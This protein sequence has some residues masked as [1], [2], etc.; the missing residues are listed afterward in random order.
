[1]AT[2]NNQ[3]PANEVGVIGQMYENRKTKKAG[4]LESR[5]EKF[6]TLMMRDNDGKAFNI[7]FSTFRSD[8]RKYQ[9]EE[10]IQTSTQIEEQKA[11]EKKEVTEAKKEVKK[12]KP[13]TMSTEEKV[14]AVKAVRKLLDE[15]I[16]ASSVELETKTLSNGGTVI[17]AK[18]KKRTLVE[19]WLPNKFP[20][21]YSFRMRE[22]LDKF[23]ETSEKREFLE[24][25]VNCVRYRPKKDDFESFIKVIITAIEKFV[26]ETDFLNKEKNE[27]NEEKE[28]N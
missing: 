9:G 10:V 17:K 20:D 14:K 7:N 22:D 5:D 12:E 25:D 11:E 28:K 4:V 13:A 3:K 23:V 27:K 19:V 1:M 6:K 2:K 18:G 26:E 21:V 16:K 24:K 8:W 15:A